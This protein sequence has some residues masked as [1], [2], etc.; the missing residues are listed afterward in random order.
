MS[1]DGY[2]QLDEALTIN[3]DETVKLAKK[4]K[5]VKG[6]AAT[7]VVDLQR[8][9]VLRDLLFNFEKDHHLTEIKISVVES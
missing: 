2:E 9:M 7:E 4:L 1:E 8:K 5:Q 3:Y 6:R